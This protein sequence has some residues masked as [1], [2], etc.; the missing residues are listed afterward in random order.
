MLVLTAL[1]RDILLHRLEIADTIAECLCDDDGSLDGDAI[2]STAEMLER[3]VVAGP[4]SGDALALPYAAAVLANAVEHSVYHA[5]A[6]DAHRDRVISA[7][8][9]AAVERAAISLA[10]KVGRFIG[11]PLVPSL[12]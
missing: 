6:E 12:G 2:A 11:R 7:Q 10:A 9:L 8:K 4:L 5:C 3:L 1:E